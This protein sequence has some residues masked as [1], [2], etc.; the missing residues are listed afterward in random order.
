MH[1]RRFAVL[2]LL[3]GSLLPSLLFAATVRPPVSPEERLKQIA[4]AKQGEL[5][6]RPTFCSCGIYWGTPEQK[7][8]S[9]EYRKVGSA[10]WKKALTPCYYKESSQYSG[11]IVKLEEDTDYEIR[12]RS[13]EKNLVSGKFRTWSGTVP[14]AK[15]IVLDPAK[16]KTKLVISEQ[17]SP[18]GWIRYT[19]KPGTCLD[20][21]DNTRLFDVSNASYIL[22]DGLTIKGGTAANVIKIENSH[23]VRIINCDISRWGVVGVPH[24]EK[25]GRRFPV[26]VG[27]KVKGY[28][29]NFNGAIVIDKGCS[30]VVVER[31]YVHDPRGQANSWFYSHPAGPEAVILKRPAHS[32]VIR[33]NDFIGS[34]LHRWNDAVEGEGNFYADGG[35]NRD[36]DIYGNFMIFCNDDNIELDGGQQ[37][38][39]CFRNRFESAHCGV[40]IQGCMVGPSYVFENLF[41]GMGE[42][43][44]LPGQTIKTGGGE[45]GREARSF[46]FNNT[47]WGDG[48][49]LIIMRTLQCDVRNNLF[50]GEQSI[51]YTKKNNSLFTANT[52]AVPEHKDGAFF[53]EE[54]SSFRS[55]ET[56]DFAL[57]VPQEGVAIPN[58]FDEKP[59]RG[60][61]QPGERDPMHRPLPVDLS[62]DR[63]GNV[64]VK[65]GAVTPRQVKFT[66]TV[67]ADADFAGVFRIAQNEA[68]DWFSVTP[69]SGILR[70]GQPMEFTVTFRGE[71][72][73]DRRF[74][75]GAFALRFTDGL[76]RPVSIYSETDF[77]PALKPV[78]AGTKT[79]YRDA[80]K[81]ASGTPK[82]VANPASSFGKSV[83][84]E[85]REKA[86]LTYDFNVTESGRY[87][88]LIHGQGSSPRLMTALDGEEPAETKQQTKQ[89]YPTWTILAPGGDF[90]CKIKYYDLKPGRHTLR[91]KGTR[92]T[93]R[94]DQ[95]VMT[96]S[97]GA[98]EPR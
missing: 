74:Y 43:Q 75:R 73:R 23:H 85:G 17:G 48:S 89:A 86:E 58:F 94:F 59:S 26:P 38:V 47:L 62:L 56:G 68:F 27:Q 50:C 84:F 29:I 4:P 49:G 18:D 92:N 82:I 20:V 46:L 64:R 81:P 42:E 57:A 76:S 88:F 61:I 13:G 77:V 66:A 10:Q 70:P 55:A 9:L 30:A 45:H 79:V 95:L 41:A 37:N 65:N 80:F 11:S 97:P 52:I 19:M 78:P 35:F 40:S 6:L 3:A 71:K 25:L 2:L 96:D 44:D 98:F 53:R 87:Y 60:A 67:R 24:Y 39:R 8:L 54:E 51:H 21:P 36:A 22:L 69:A 63:I 34:D 32:T 16:F 14:V 31:C 12:F 90:N 28:G 83:I 91:L 72:M 93:L 33:Y 1:A 15:T 5:L 7:S